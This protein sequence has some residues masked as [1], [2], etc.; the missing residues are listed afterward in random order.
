ME[1]GAL[2]LQTGFLP[3]VM[4]GGCLLSY[5]ISSLLNGIWG[6]FTTDWFPSEHN[7]KIGRYYSPFGPQLAQGRCIH[8]K[9]GRWQW[10]VRTTDQF[11][12]KSIDAYVSMQGVR[13]ISCAIMAI[14]QFLAHAMLARWFFHALGQR[15]TR[16]SYS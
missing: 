11:N 5:S 7:A 3:T 10:S 6:P 16:S 13:C 12:S 1:S 14:F 9:L 8:R 4:T 2:L 15:Y